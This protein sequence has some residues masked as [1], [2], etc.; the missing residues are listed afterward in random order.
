MQVLPWSSSEVQRSFLC[1]LDFDRVW[2]RR[3]GDSLCKAWESPVPDWSWVEDFHSVGQQRLTQNRR[4][5]SR[6]CR[7]V[8]LPQGLQ[9]RSTCIRSCSRT[10]LKGVPATSSAQHT[11]TIHFYPL[12]ESQPVQRL[13]RTC[14]H[15]QSSSDDLI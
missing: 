11:P 5:L 3:K 10:A 7:G 8:C 6:A 4:S 13:Y 14:Q 12:G 15:K 2:Q 1:C 9:H